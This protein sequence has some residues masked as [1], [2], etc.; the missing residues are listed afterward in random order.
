MAPGMLSTMALRSSPA[1]VAPAAATTRSAAVGPWPPTSSRAIRSSEDAAMPLSSVR[2]DG[3]RR[4]ATAHFVAQGTSTIAEF[5]EYY[6]R[7]VE[8]AENNK[9]SEAQIAGIYA[10]R[11]RSAAGRGLAQLQLGDR[12]AMHLIR[13][14][15]HAQRARHGPA[16]GQAEIVAEAGRAV[17]LDGAIHHLERHVRRHD[18]DH[19]DLGARRLVADAVHR[20]GRLQHQK[21]RL[22]DR[23]ARFGDGG[24]DDALLGERLAERDAGLGP[25]AHRLERAL[26]QADQPHAVMDAARAEPTLGDLEAPPLAQQHVRLRH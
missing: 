6:S 22:V 1:A 15:G 9:R 26:G 10:P 2:P 21:P 24:H 12:L 8:P 18:L 14:V 16:M 23:D 25:G 4:L 3:E 5:D 13:T 11:S 20:L 17:H 19:G 7:C